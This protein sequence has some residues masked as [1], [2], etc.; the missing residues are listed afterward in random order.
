MMSSRELEATIQLKLNFVILV[1]RDKGFGMIRWK[2][3]A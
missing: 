1:L 2:Q 3:Y